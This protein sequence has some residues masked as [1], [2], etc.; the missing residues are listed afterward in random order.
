VLL[1]GC[2]TMAGMGKDIQTGGEKVE[3]AADSVKQK[4]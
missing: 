2:N 1:V 3:S 4:M